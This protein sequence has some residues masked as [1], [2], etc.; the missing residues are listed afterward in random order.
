[1]YGP[2]M[3]FLY[4]WSTITALRPASMAMQ[5]F[6]CSKYA[7]RAV[8]HLFIGS[9]DVTDIASLDAVPA[10]VI[11]LVAAAVVCTVSAINTF[12]IRSGSHTTLVL[13]MMKLLALLTIIIIGLVVYLSGH[14]D[15]GFTSQLLWEGSVTAPGQYV[16]ALIGAMYVRTPPIDSTQPP[17]H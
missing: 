14:Q 8:Y 15:Q 2:F 5:A 17:S 13:S 3:G 16:L 10:F 1:M 11:K 4:S 12:S 9:E 6:I 7:C